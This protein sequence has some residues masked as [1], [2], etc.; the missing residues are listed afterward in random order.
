MLRAKI[1]DQD[2][3]AAAGVLMRQG[4][5]CAIREIE[6]RLKADASEAP[7]APHEPCGTETV[8]QPETRSE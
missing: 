3:T 2:T 4:W 1:G 5:D 6:E 8:K 7:N